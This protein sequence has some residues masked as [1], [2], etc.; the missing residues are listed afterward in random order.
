MK[1]GD[2]CTRSTVIIQDDRQVKDAAKLMKQYNI[3]SLVVVRSQKDNRMPIIPI[4]IITDRDIVIKAMMD[5]NLHEL[6]IKEIMSAPVITVQEHISIF[7]TLAKMRY[8]GIRRVPVVN[9]KG[10]LAGI[11]TL[12]DIMDFLL[13]EISEISQIFKKEEPVL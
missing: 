5:G 4:G 12:D 10:H 6:E 8:N 13:T 9:E 7:D 11:I 3:G 2:I 1:S